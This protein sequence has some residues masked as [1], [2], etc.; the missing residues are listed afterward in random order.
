M[1]L[2]LFEGL[3]KE[4]DMAVVTIANLPSN[5]E[6]PEGSVAYDAQLYAQRVV[7]RRLRASRVAS[8]TRERMFRLHWGEEIPIEEQRLSQIGFQALSAA[9]AGGAVLEGISLLPQVLTQ[10]AESSTSS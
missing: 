2:S 10:L 7:W 9:T 4:S 6:T 3:H 5:L 8:G 1:A